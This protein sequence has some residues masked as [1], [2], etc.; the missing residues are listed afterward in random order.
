MFRGSWL[1]ITYYCV[2]NDRP[3]T[4]TCTSWNAEPWNAHLYYQLHLADTLLM[5]YSSP[6]RY[7]VLQFIMTGRSN[8]CSLVIERKIIIGKCNTYFHHN[9]EVSNLTSFLFMLFLKLIISS[10]LLSILAI[11]FTTWGILHFNCFCQ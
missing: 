1:H 6:Y 8:G 3:A 10:I 4:Q 2:W 9:N 7:R 5:C 11:Y